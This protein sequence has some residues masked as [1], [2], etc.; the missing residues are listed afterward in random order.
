MEKNDF[1]L[2]SDDKIIPKIHIIRGIQVM[3]DSDLAA[4]YG[5]ETKYFN[6]QVN[7]NLNR[8]DEDFRFQ[9]TEDEVKSLR[10]KNFTSSW[11]GTRYQPYVFTEQGVYMLMT[12][13]KGELAVRQSK[14][15][16]RL[17]KQMKDFVIQGQNILACPD[18]LKISIQT[19]RNTE[20]IKRIKQQMVSR[21]NLSALIRDF[22]DP[23][24]RKDF[25]F[26]NGQTVESAIAY[27]EI[28]SAAKTAIHI[29]DNYISL[30]TL[31]LLKS[32]GTG[33]KVT[34]FSDNVNRGLHH[35]EFI[36]FRHEYPNVDI[37]LKTTGGICH[38]RYIFVD[39]GTAFA[40]IFHCGGSSK[41]GG[42]RI[43]SISQVEDMGLYQNILTSLESNPPLFL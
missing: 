22:T 15:L 27:S 23:N 14:T 37:E 20:D 42:K 10:C 30:K 8:F 9:L 41:D 5:Y 28:Y 13:L 25:V 1:V 21:D 6:R 33:V 18:V 19:E 31:I 32:V 2:S 36:D 16:I 4:F 17:F 7:N 11:G 26:Y 34:N 40:K 24:I 35:S 3:L 12:V 38:D 29:I 39:Y 43:T